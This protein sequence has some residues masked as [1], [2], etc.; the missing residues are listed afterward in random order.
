MK[1]CF[2]LLNLLLFAATAVLCVIYNAEGGLWLKGLTASGFLALGV[3]NLV[4]AILSRGVDLRYPIRLV[5]G[6]AVC[7]TA[8]IVLNLSFI[9]GAL[10]FALGHLLYFVAYC[11]LEPLRAADWLPIGCMFALSVAILKLVP[12]L[13]FSTPLLEWICLGYGLVISCMVGKTAANFS[14]RRNAVNGL[15]LAGSLLFYFSDLMLVL[16]YF[17]NAPAITDALCLF[18]YFPGQCVLAHSLYHYTAQAS[19]PAGC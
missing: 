11:K 1:Q 9:P 13:H 7:L 5:L 8:D 15:L 10:I 16:C 18:T 6:L 12:I 4:F 19:R 17:G 2:R 3:V 14:R